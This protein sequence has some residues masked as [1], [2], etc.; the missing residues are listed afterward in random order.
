MSAITFYLLKFMATMVILA[1]QSAPLLA[2]IGKILF[3]AVGLSSFLLYLSWK[4]GK[5][6]R[7][8]AKAAH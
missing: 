1:I 6:M 2:E 3:V 7:V 5:K 4:G 8:A